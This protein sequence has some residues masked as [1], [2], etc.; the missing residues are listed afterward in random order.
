M[1]A[2]FDKIYKGTYKEFVQKIS[3]SLDREKKEFI[4]T[5]NPETFMIGDSN[6][7]FDSILRADHTTIVPDGIGVVKAANMLG[8]PLKDRITGVELCQD[9]LRLLDN[10][11][12][13][14]YLFGAREEVGQALLKKIK[15]T[16]PNIEILGYTDGYVQEKER[17]ME[18]IVK[19]EPDV[20][21][22]ALGIPHQELLIDKYYE[23]AS[24]GIFLGVG[25]SFDVL[26]GMKKRAPR[27]FIKC[28]MEWLYRIVSE[29]KR[30]G[31]FYKSNVRFIKKV[32]LLQRGTGHED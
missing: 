17:A 2:Y 18:E 26:S 1:K 24:K 31:R 22:V 15:G 19:K 32:R 8:I 30:I 5:A 6:P 29:P 13:R 25:G 7:A 27:I 4:V 11:S 21:L 10:K 9:L 28:N 20:I 14:L 3:E 16:Y 12:K 23:R